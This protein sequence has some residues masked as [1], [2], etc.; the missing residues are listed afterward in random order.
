MK[1]KPIT[2]VL[3]IFVFVVAIG[4]AILLGPERYMFINVPTAVFVIL[5]AGGLGLASYRDGG[6]LG[7]IEACKK[8]FITAGILGTIIGTIQ[9]LAIV[10]NPSGIG[11]G[12]AVALLSVC[13]GVVLYC[14]SDALVG[15]K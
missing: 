6:L 5:V 8:H 4:V 12:F 3:G 14:I 15:G 11:V 1:A 9:T 7:Y 2:V 13:Y 10:E